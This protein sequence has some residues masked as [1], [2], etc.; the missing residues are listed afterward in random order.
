VVT[1]EGVKVNVLENTETLMNLVIPAKMMSLPDDDLGTA[2]GGN[3]C[4]WAML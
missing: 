4:W 1:P 3:A 2:V